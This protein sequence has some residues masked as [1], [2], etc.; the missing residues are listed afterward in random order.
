[1]PKF[2]HNLTVVEAHREK[3]AGQREM[4]NGLVRWEDGY[5]TIENIELG[6]IYTIPHPVFMILYKPSDA[7][8]RAYLDAVAPEGRA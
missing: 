1:M 8:A 7:E 3:V 2:V 5:W 4:E 6:V